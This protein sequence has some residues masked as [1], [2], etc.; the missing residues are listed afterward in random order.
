MVPVFLSLLM[1][2]RAAVWD[3]V[4]GLAYEGAVHVQDFVRPVAGR[5]PGNGEGKS[6]R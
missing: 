3:E 2:P 4:F 5:G 6:G 1:K